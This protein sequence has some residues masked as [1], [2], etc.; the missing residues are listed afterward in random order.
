MLGEINNK[1]PKIPDEFKK[2]NSR[3]NRIAL[4]VLDQIEPEIKTA[5][6]RYGSD[7]VAVIVGTSTSGISDAETALKKKMDTGSLPEEFYYEHQELGNL[8]EFIANYYDIEGP[9]YTISTACSSS[10]RVF[11]SA[12][13]MLY[14]GVVDAVIVGGVDS[15]CKLTVNGFDSL[16]AISYKL[17][18]PFSKNRDGINIGEGGGFILLSLDKNDSDIA[19]LGAGDSSDAHH[20]S[21]PHPEG[22]GAIESMKKALFDA[23]LEPSDIGYINA[24]GTSTKLNDSMESKAIYALFSR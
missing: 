16:G 24:H 5:I 18:N 3:N 8:S 1:L 10:G 21:A 13:R 14:A 4:S 19:F 2:Y 6:N 12:K 15:L 9:A 17:C 23:N 7:K 11:L 22:I 20:I